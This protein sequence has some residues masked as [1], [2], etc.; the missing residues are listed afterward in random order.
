MALS[1]KVTRRTD[2]DSTG[3]GIQLPESQ[4]A[5][6]PT[7]RRSVGVRPA[8]RARI[9]PGGRGLVDRTALEVPPGSSR[10]PPPRCSRCPGDLATDPSWSCSCDILSSAVV[11]PAWRTDRGHD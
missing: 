3:A 10:L 11:P 7:A 9:P 6:A 5:A 4:H 1:V 8:V 2:H